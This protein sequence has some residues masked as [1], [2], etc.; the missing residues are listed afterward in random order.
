MKSNIYRVILGIIFPALL[1]FL[2]ILFYGFDHGP[3]CWIGLGFI[4]LSYLTMML[5]PFF[6]PNSKSSHL[7]G[8]TSGVIT[9]V[10]FGID[11]V[12]GLIFVFFDFE[13]WKIA[14][15]TEI[16]LLVV[17]LALF[18]P[19]LITDEET[20]KKEN[21]RQEQ[22]ISVK[23]L[24]SKVKII[25]NMVTDS[26]LKSEVLRVYDELNSCP[27]NS[28][29]ATV[30]IDA[31]ISKKLETLSQ[32]VEKNDNAGIKEATSELLKIIKERKEYS[33]F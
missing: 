28:N 9:S 15:G 2:L 26:Q 25:A 24:V 20:A 14:L 10:Y 3:T 31:K 8:F 17:F 21:T 13:Q 6:V 29:S 27:S 19:I 18:L 1:F 22:I 16:V 5:V 4:I 23:L 7:F 11:L 32:A 30:S 12:V 33:K